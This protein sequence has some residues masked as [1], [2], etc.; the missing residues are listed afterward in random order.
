MSPRSDATPANKR[1][2]DAPEG[3]TTSALNNAFLTVKKMG[4]AKKNTP[5]TEPVDL[6]DI[7]EMSLADRALLCKGR[8]V[9][10]FAGNDFI[11]DLPQAL[12]L[13][14]SINGPKLLCG[15]NTIVLPTGTDKDGVI[16]LVKYLDNIA[17]SPKK[18]SRIAAKLETFEDLSTCAAAQLLGMEKYTA[19]IMNLYWAWFA[20][21]LP[22]YDDLDAIMC[23]P[24]S[25]T[26]LFDLV[27]SQLA[28]LVRDDQV[29]DPED[30][31]V[32][33]ANNARLAD[34][35]ADINKKAAAKARREAARERR[36]KEFEAC[37]QRREE[38]EA[39]RAEDEARRLKAQKERE[40]KDKAFWEDKKKTEKEL[41]ARVQEKMRK[42]AKAFTKEEAAHIRKTRGK[43][44]AAV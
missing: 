43:T 14:T 40:A 18:P 8:R 9:K 44:V 1:T 5:N 41:E 16:R 12:L 13:M 33:L 22:D 19:N 11:V 23:F 38:A 4:K 42:G 36:R 7:R 10:I 6:K 3:P 2:V 15:G 20:N 17:R 31:A 34:K 24:T 32:Y 39:R 35:I 25:H 37:Q 21:S 28:S 29:P 30:F 26:R 27:A